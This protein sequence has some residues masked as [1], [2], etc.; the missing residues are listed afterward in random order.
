[1]LK[2]AIA[3]IT[4]FA[5]MLQLYVLLN[6]GGSILNYFSYFTILTNL[7]VAISFTVPSP[8]FSKPEV[9]AGIT[10][11]IAIVGMVYS[12]L[13]RHLWKPAGWQLVADTL[14]HDVVPLLAV[15]YWILFVPKGKLKWVHALQWLIYPTCYLIYTLLRGVYPYPFIDIDQLGVEQAVLNMIYLGIAFVVLGF[16]LVGIDRLFRPR[17]SAA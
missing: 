13:L 10:L 12:L 1:M 8:F 17:R 3:I 11:Y 4:W 15:L 6:N 7:L 2:A 14:L 16:G 9:R 5:L